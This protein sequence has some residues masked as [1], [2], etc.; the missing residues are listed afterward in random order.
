MTP[1]EWKSKSKEV[2]VL[3]E[4]VTNEDQLREFAMKQQTIYDMHDNV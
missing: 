1:E 4:G 3:A 2:F